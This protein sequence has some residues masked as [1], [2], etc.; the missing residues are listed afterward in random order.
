[1]I[2][3]TT[4]EMRMRLKRTL[5]SIHDQPHFKYAKGPKE[6]AEVDKVLKTFVFRYLYYVISNDGEYLPQLFGSTPREKFPKSLEEAMDVERAEL[7]SKSSKS[8]LFYVVDDSAT[9][10]SHRHTGRNCGRKFQAGEPI[11]R[12]TECSFDDTCVLCIYCFNPEDHINHHVNTAICTRVNNGMCDCGDVEAWN[13][14]LACKAEKDEEGLESED[15]FASAEMAHLFQIV[16]AEVFDHFLDVFNQNIEPLPTFQREITVKLREAA[17]NDDSPEKFQLLR[18]LEYTNEYIQEQQMESE[19]WPDYTVL[20]YNDE[21]HNYS[22]ATAA[23]KQGVPDDKHTDKL[24]ARIDGEGRAMLK[25]SKDI[26]TI[27]SGY[28]AVRTNGLSA[29]LTTWSEYIQQETCKYVISWISH[30]LTIPNAA[31]QQT[32][33][34]AMGKVL[35]SEFNNLVQ[36]K[37]VSLTVDKHFPSKPGEENPY[38][39]ADLSVLDQKNGIPFS[40]HKVLADGE[41]DYISLELNKTEPPAHKKYANSRLQHILFFDNRYWKRL[42]K[43]IQDVIIP[44]LSS[45]V[46]FKPIF[47]AHLVQMYNHMTRSLAFIDR[48]PQLT[49]L[50]E[51]VVQLF[52]CPTNAHSIFESGSFSD[53]MWSVIDIFTEFSKK[54]AGV[55]VWQKVKKTNPTKS[56]SLS[57]KQ[58]L[59]AVETILS[60]ISDPNLLLRP[61]EFIA[62]VTL[63][64][65][66]FQWSLENQA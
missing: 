30:C 44:T 2:R 36:G 19:E 46:T 16:L 51:S 4:D 28:F 60:K 64:K 66:A 48:E 65:L 42:R 26:S 41:L 57:F 58:S 24:T 49:A 15:V 38:R 50:R 6:R 52:T 31:F 20:V 17:Q 13:V 23:L 10:K 27:L 21:Y 34:D 59:Y 11:Y 63:C 9:N 5:Q 3:E 54:D 1:M 18:D 14:P 33:R 25:C 40:H 12:C 55:L 47:C 56:Y 32:F 35:C 43:D 22:Q 39:Y 62:I 61:Q 45:S 29:T 53:I 7:A 8:D 37:N